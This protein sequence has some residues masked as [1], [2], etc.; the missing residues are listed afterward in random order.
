M[1]FAAFVVVAAAL[2]SSLC[3]C[4]SEPVSG[5]LS[6]SIIKSTATVEELDVANR[7]VTL[8]SA[9]GKL[10]PMK[11]TPEVRRLE[12][13][14][15][16]DQVVVSYKES[17]AWEVKKPGEAVEGVTVVGGA[18][19]A[20]EGEMPAAGAANI[21]TVTVT[22]EAIDKSVPSITLRRP[23]GKSFVVK[24]KD[25]EKLERVA[26]GELVEITYTEALAVSVQRKD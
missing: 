26:V 6:E 14:K 24:V 9:D 3:A 7:R 19:R 4:A 12:D 15:V 1:R 20:N 25:R 21:T 16:G 13:V 5:T 23:D 2:T 11:V 22:I 10:I 17:V 18:A 8:R